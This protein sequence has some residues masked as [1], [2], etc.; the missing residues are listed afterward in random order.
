MVIDTWLPNATFLHALSIDP[1]SSSRMLCKGDLAPEEEG[2]PA[3]LERMI[4]QLP[5]PHT[6]QPLTAS[7]SF[8]TPV[9]LPPH[10]P[11]IF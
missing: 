9:P 1:L 2:R 6:T 7:L 11:L 4:H 8:T 10:G 3:F 5:P